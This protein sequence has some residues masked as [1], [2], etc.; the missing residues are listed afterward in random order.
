MNQVHALMRCFRNPLLTAVERS[1][2]DAVSS[3]L[4]AGS[5]ANVNDRRGKSALMYAAESGNPTIVAALIEAGA[6]V[7][8]ETANSMTALMHCAHIAGFVL[9]FDEGACRV[10]PAAFGPRV[11]AAAEGASP[12]RGQIFRAEPFR[13]HRELANAALLRGAVAFVGRGGCTFAEKAARCAEAGAIAMIVANNDAKN[14]AQI[15]EMTAFPN[16]ECRIPLAMMQYEDKGRV[17]DGTMVTLAVRDSSA[18]RAA[19]CVEALFAAGAELDAKD[20]HGT[21]ALMHACL[22]GHFAVFEAL[23]ES[24]ADPE[25]I[26]EE[27]HMDALLIASQ[28]NHIKMVQA[29]IERGVDVRSPRTPGGPTALILAAHLAEAPLIEV[30]LAAGSDVE[31]ELVEAEPGQADGSTALLFACGSC[32]IH[33]NDDVARVLLDVGGADPNVRQ[34]LS[35]QHAFGS[36]TFLSSTLRVRRNSFLLTCSI[37]FLSFLSTLIGAE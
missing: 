13:A 20:S 36:F 29:L 21:T 27:D 16:V 35:F 24:G 31:A 18:V 19:Q 17:R 5:S 10:L 30:L 6:D 25:C 1:D 14:P 7:S 8:Y 32:P 34:K 23:L 2:E 28:G 11:D 26:A 3:L 37:R 33:G 9:R 15:F 12:V 4:A 22:E